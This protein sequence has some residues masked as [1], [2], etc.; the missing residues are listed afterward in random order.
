MGNLVNKLVL[1]MGLDK[2]L[3][4]H[5]LMTLWPAIVGDVLAAKS[6]CLFIDYEGKLV[7]SVKDASVGQELSLQKRELM[8]KVGAAAHG[9]QLKIEGMRFDLKHFF[10]NDSSEFESVNPTWLALPKPS[11]ADLEAVILSK[12]E[13]EQIADF[14]R[15]MYQGEAERGSKFSK[16]INL[17]SRVARLFEHELRLRK[18]QKQNGYPECAQCGQPV[19]QLHTERLLCPQCFFVSAGL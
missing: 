15:A 16:E 14:Q 17:N 12:E 2:R 9:L 3:K 10:K 4:E 11:P 13:L 7:V 19:P 8:K 1:D 6:R 5:A 18:W